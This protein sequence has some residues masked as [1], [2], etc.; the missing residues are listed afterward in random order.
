MSGKKVLHLDRNDYY[1]AE[2][3]SI[4]PLDKLYEKFGR[5]GKAPENFGRGRDWNVDLIPKFIMADGAPHSC[6]A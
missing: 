4:S 6:V 5:P 1:G 2:S 3:A